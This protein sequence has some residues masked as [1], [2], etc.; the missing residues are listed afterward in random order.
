[1]ALGGAL[2]DAVGHLAMS[3]SLGEVL[4]MPATGYA[5]VYHLELALLFATLAVLGPLVTRRR[6]TTPPSP[7][8][9]GSEPRRF[10]LA[11]FPG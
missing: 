1:V 7:E 9:S 2:R 11:D 6:T 3:G 5:F 10:G 4:A 8:A